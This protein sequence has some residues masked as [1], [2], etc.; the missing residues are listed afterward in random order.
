MCQYPPGLQLDLQDIILTIHH[1]K[2]VE[3]AIEGFEYEGELDPA[4][5]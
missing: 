4:Q 1:L 2:N 5:F 3:K